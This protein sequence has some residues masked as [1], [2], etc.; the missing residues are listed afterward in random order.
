MPAWG[1]RSSGSE[2]SRSYLQQQ[3]PGDAEAVQ[4]ADPQTA[5]PPPGQAAHQRQRRR[6]G[7]EAEGHVL[8]HTDSGG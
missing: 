5:A 2:T 7:R 3:R 8:L 4:L 6:R 1:Q